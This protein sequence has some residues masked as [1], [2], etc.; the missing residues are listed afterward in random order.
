MIRVGLTGNAASGKTTVAGY[1]RDAGVP[2]IDADR[3]GHDVLAEDARVREGLVQAFGHGILDGAG[4]IDRRALGERAFATPDG[5]RRLNALVHPPLLERL[6]RAL[7]EAEAAGHPVAAVDAALVFEFNLD[8]ALDRIVLVTAP[9]ERRARRLREKRGMSALQIERLMAAQLSDTEKISD[10][11]HVI[12]NDG[13]LDDL[14]HRA[15]EVLETIR[16][17]CTHTYEEEQT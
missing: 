10:S 6:D 9:E 8:E 7:E 4:Q 3:I 11:D 12:V 5:V 2:V 15:E 13:T 1:W 14:R 16:S 17:D